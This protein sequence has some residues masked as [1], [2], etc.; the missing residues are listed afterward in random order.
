[1]F[2]CDNKGDYLLATVSGYYSLDLF[3]TAIHEVSEHCK[4]ENLKKALLDL[5]NL[6]GDP[7]ILDR[8]RFGL[9]IAKAWGPLLKVA[10]VAKPEA[11]N[12]MGENT[13]VNRGANVWATPDMELALQWLG[14]EHT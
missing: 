3:I 12:K 2:T 5:R 9:E 1:M 4:K 10:A 11:I 8:Y 14:V 6:E 7:S 13:A